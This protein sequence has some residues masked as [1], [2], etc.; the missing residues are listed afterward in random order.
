M[1]ELPQNTFLGRLALVRTIEHYDFPRLF[2]C[3]NTTQQSY[4]V[5]STYDDDERCEWL[6]LPVSSLRLNSILTGEISL[7]NGF[8]MSEGGFVLAVTTFPNEPTLI[9]Y[10]LPEQLSED[11]LPSADYWLKEDLDTSKDE[12]IID[13]KAVASASR[14]ETFNYRIFPDNKS[15]H[16]IAAR[17]L[18]GI[19]TNTQE[20]IDALGQAV[21]G[22]PTVRGPLPL[23]L[24]SQTKVNVAH[25]FRGSFGVQFRAG[26]H[27]DLFAD[28]K[29]SEALNE[30]GNL[31]SAA[32]SEDLLSNKLHALKGRVA[33][34]YRRLLKELND[35]NSGLVL[36]W[37]SVNANR[38]GTYS[39][40]SE[41]VAQAYLIVDRIDIE[42]S[43]EISVEGQL[44]G[45]NS[46]THRYEIRA[47][48]GGKNYSGKVA[49]D[50]SLPPLP[51][52]DQFYVARL[53]M[54]VETQSSS[55]DELIRW[56]L[57]HLA[58]R[59]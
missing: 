15:K 5:L 36:D 34:K 37:G 6:Y 33:S 31:L 55:G 44:V 50:A 26:Q 3:Q 59:P 10:R 51:T 43:D 18:G 53:R 1:F 23:E 27:S 14:R 35:V 40:T 13:P 21:D 54:L 16:E 58:E 32:D 45:F 29:V 17:K 24:L 12:A 28:S 57:V 56:V 42:M 19:L 39:L 30:F 48:D 25:V 20:L 46:R 41:Q 7:L 52:I 22:Q 4:L 49:L 9:E 8:L 47:T 2:T 38:G 11:D